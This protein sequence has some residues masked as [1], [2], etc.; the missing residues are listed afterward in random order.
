MDLGTTENLPVNVE[1]AG[2]RLRFPMGS[3]ATG[4]W[5]DAEQ[6]NLGRRV[7]VKVL[8]PDLVHHEGARKEFLQEMDR[9]APLDHPN[10]PHVL[11]TVREATL[12]LVLEGG[13]ET[14]VAALLEARR[15]IGEARA[16]HYAR[17]VARALLY[18]QGKGLAHK[19]VTPSFLH[20]LDEERLRLITFRNVVPWAEFASAKG[21]ISQDPRYVAPEQ[22]GGE[23]PIGPRTPVY[24]V[25]ALLYHL[26]TGRPPF[27]A[28]SPVETAKAHLN[29]EFPSLKK[30]LP[31]PKKGLVPFVNACTLQNPEER[32]DLAAVCAGL[33]RLLAGEDPG[34]APA[35]NDTGEIV[36]RPKRRRRRY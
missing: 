20:V 2:Y 17:C 28:G 18:L 25:G 13:P 29:E 1:I 19:N 15:G 6:I 27:E 22:V 7:L 3:D 9:L 11:D 34:I 4:V 32:P 24:Q 14:T 33:D 26:L 21:K 35:G 36:L 31:F 5:L 23:D 10:I 8:R 12:V 30:L 16:L